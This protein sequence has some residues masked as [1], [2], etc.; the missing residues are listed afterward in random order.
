MIMAISHYSRDSL[1]CKYED[2]STEDHLWE[3]R[4]FVDYREPNEYLPEAI[5]SH[6]AKAW[7]RRGVVV[8]TGAERSFFHLIFSD[9]N[10]CQGLVIRDINPIIIAYVNFNILLLKVAIDRIDYE[11]L[12]SSKDSLLEIRDRVKVSTIPDRFRFFYLRNFESFSNAYYGTTAFWKGSTEFQAVHYYKSDMQFQILKAYAVAGNIIAT[13]GDINNLC[14]LNRDEVVDLDVSN[15][16]QS[17]MIDICVENREGPPT[18]IWTRLSG[19]G[20]HYYSMVYTGLSLEEKE[21]MNLYLSRIKSNCEEGI[22][23]LQLVNRLVAENW[24]REG[25]IFMAYSKAILEDLRSSAAN[26]LIEVPH[27]GWIDFSPYLGFSSTLNRMNHCPLPHLH[28]V[29]K[30]PGMEKYVEILTPVWRGVTLPVYAAFSEIPNWSEAF[31]RYCE[32]QQDN[33]FFTRDFLP[34]LLRFKSQQ[35]NAN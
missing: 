21:E 25:P 34:R 23:L 13:L 8:S 10:L 4:R 20:A 22:S 7:N 28:E 14:F 29:C 12:S 17:S 16:D 26:W 24:N 3:Q 11:R 5:E 32:E 9:H 15:I 31:S 27:L 2:V 30:A 35:T 1:E 18:L 19:E 33:R 6:V